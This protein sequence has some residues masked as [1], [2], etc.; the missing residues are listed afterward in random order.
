MFALR[1]ICFIHSLAHS[2]KGKQRKDFLISNITPMTL[3]KFLFISLLSVLIFFRFLYIYR[4]LPLSIFFTFLLPFLPWI[5]FILLFSIFPSHPA[6]SHSFVP[7]YSPPFSP[8]TLSSTPLC[9]PLP[10]LSLCRHMRGKGSFC[11]S[12]LY[13]NFWVA[14]FHS[15]SP[16]PAFMLA[17]FLFFIKISFILDVFVQSLFFYS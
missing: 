14:F 4:H 12:P 11:T 13:I 16:L 10:S 1:R 7:F 15:F 9:Y 5:C 6:S 2:R 3:R 17:L 8:Q